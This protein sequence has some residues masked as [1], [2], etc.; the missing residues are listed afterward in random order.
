MAAVYGVV[1][2]KTIRLGIFD[3]GNV[4]KGRWVR[5]DGHHHRPFIDIRFSCFDLTLLGGPLVTI[6][7]RARSLI[8]RNTTTTTDGYS[9]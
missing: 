6:I 4:F 9:G 7:E 5:L 8:H 3:M 2:S 1:G